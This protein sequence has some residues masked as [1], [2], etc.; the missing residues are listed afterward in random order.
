[1]ILFLGNIYVPPY[2]NSIC[3][4]CYRVVHKYF[5]KK[6]SLL[7]GNIYVPPYSNS[8]CRNCY[9]VE[10]PQKL[11][12]CV[13]PNI[14]QGKQTS[15]IKKVITVAEPLER[16]LESPLES[17]LDSLLES[18]LER[19]LESPIE[20]ESIS[21]VKNIN[22]ILYEERKKIKSFKDKV[23]TKLF[24]LYKKIYKRKD[25]DE[26]KYEISGEIVDVDN[27]EDWKTFVS[28]LP[29]KFSKSLLG[30][31]KIVNEA[32]TELLDV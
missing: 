17:P 2:S 23:S 10:I 4:N 1:M 19:P 13:L 24:N 28:N 25:E 22:K 9:T 8:I 7:L 32:I 27:Y 30:T 31:K 21:N 16:P 15:A 6:V 14:V 11:Y 5:L 20:K 18:P 12:G 26:I 29:N 3:R